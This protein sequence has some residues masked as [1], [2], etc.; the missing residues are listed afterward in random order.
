MKVCVLGAG[1]LG[2]AI[3]GALALSGNEVHLVSRPAHAAAVNERGLTLVA[4][5]EERV[6]TVVGHDTPE[7]IGPAA[8]VPTP[9][10]RTLVAMVHG[11]ERRIGA[12]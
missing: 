6:A 5:D 3:G 10:N 4:G 11:I 9:V 7:G 1:S 8:G 12:R 2:S